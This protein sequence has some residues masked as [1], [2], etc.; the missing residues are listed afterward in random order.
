[1]IRALV[2]ALALSAVLAGCGTPTPAPQLNVPPA[3]TAEQPAPAP[4]AGGQQSERGN[5]V[6]QLGE[7]AAFGPTASGQVDPVVTFA[8]DKITVGAK[9]TS[10]Y[11]QPAE[12]GNLVRIDLRA[13]TAKTLP[14]DG[15]YMLTGWDFST[16]GADGITETQLVT[17]AAASCLDESDMF[18]NQQFAPGSKYRGSIVIDTKNPAGAL[19]LKPSFMFGTGGWEWTYGK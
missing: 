5:L 16:V 17:G 10:A 8:V 3:S 2:A 12:H 18:H 15:F 4:A 6:K 13:E 14:T 1:M 19:I 9:C 7:S 11:P